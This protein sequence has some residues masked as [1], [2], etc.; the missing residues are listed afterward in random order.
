[1]LCCDVVMLLCFGRTAVFFSSWIVDL[2]V[3]ERVAARR[4]EGDARGER[5]REK[6]RRLSPPPR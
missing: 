5:Q 3:L 1:M 2:G 6:T 4:E